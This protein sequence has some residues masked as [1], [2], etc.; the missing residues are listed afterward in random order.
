MLVP[1]VIIFVLLLVNAFFVVAEFAIVG[2]PRSAIDARASRNDRLAKLVQTVL[3]DPQRKDMYIATAQIGITVASLGLG[4]YGEHVVADW[5]LETLGHST[6]ALWLTAHGFA[7]VVAVAVL[8]YFHIVIGEMLPKSLA[9]QAAER[10]ALWLTPPMLWIQTLIYPFVI[11]LNGVANLV[12]RPFD[13]HHERHKVDQYYTPEELQLVVEESEEQGALRPEASKVLQELFEF[14]ELTAGEVMVPR[15][16][17]TGIPVDAGPE[18]LREILG[19]TPRTRYPIFQGDL[20]HIAGT[21]HIKDLLRL[22]LNGQPVTAGGARPAPVVPE[23]ALL[24]T[25]LATMRRERAQFAVVIDEHGGTSGVVTLEDLFEEVVGEI[26]DSPERRSGPRRDA[27]GRLRVPGTMRLDEL[28]QL[29]DLD[30]V[31]EDVDS[32]SGLILTLLGRPPKIGDAIRYDR[33]ELVV[34][35]VMGHG[36]EEAAVTLRGSADDAAD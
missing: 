17:I 7:S 3:D 16:R 27:A 2:V 36:V 34:T 13:I 30:L 20:D 12:L 9:L 26:D 24:D 29:F 10:I 1:L 31:H 14:G 23:T 32:V 35:A 22:L 8:T 33:L 5:I 4:M 28:G 18:E 25:V 11:T 15:V 19:H 6:W 21:Y